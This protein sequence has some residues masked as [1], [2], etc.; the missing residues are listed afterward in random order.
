MQ[1]IDFRQAPDVLQQGQAGPDI[2]FYE[3]RYPPDYKSYSKTKPVPIEEFNLE[4]KWWARPDARADKIDQQIRDQ[5]RFR[6]YSARGKL[7][8]TPT[9]RGVVLAA[10]SQTPTNGPKT[11]LI[12]VSDTRWW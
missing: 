9:L 6:H 11:L 4:K 8:E 10:F 1:S 3:H 2:C 7:R 12:A 5:M